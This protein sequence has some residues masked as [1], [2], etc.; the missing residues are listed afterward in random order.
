M[1][2]SLHEIFEVSGLPMGDLPHEKYIPGTKELHLL[3]KDDPQVYKTYWRSC[4]T[5]T[6]TSR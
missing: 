5:S 3:K 6:S 1:E 4:A 2:F